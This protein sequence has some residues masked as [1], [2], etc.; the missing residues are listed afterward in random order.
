MSLHIS[1][2][3]LQSPHRF[4][5]YEP[6][7]RKTWLE[8]M[9]R[10]KTAPL[11]K[12]EPKQCHKGVHTKG[13]IGGQGPANPSFGMTLTTHKMQ[14]CYTQE[15]AAKIFEEEIFDAHSELLHLFSMPTL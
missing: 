5:Q 14:G 2:S 3:P 9:F 6:C 10:R 7:H 12:E 4:L 8:I 11:K 1:Q 13:R 15:V